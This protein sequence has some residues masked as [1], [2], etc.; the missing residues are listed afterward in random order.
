MPKK[1][2]NTGTT[3]NDGTGDSLKV[4]AG[5]VNDNFNEIYTAFGDGTTLTPGAV[6]G[7]AQGIKG[8]V[9]AQGP[10]GIQG[11]IGIQGNLGI[12]GVQGLSNQGI[13]GLDGQFAGQ[14]VQGGRGDIGNSGNQGVQGTQ[15][16]QGTT[17]SA[18][19]IGGPGSQGTTGPQGIQGTSGL[20]GT[21]GAQGAVGQGIQGTQ[22]IQGNFGIQGNS[23]TFGPQG[24]TGSV[25]SPGGQ[26]IQGTQ[27]T[28]G[29]QGVPGAGSQGTIG[30]IGVQ[31]NSGIQ[32][33]Q[34]LLGEGSQGTI[35]I[36]GAGGPGGLTG[37][38]GVQGTSVQGLS[39]QGV[40][41]VEGQQGPIG[42]SNG[43]FTPAANFPS[44]I[45]TSASVGIGTTE[46]N[47]E[48][49]V[50]DN[51]EKLAVGIVTCREIF[52][53][54]VSGVSTITGDVG[55]AGTIAATHL[56]AGKWTLGADGVS[57][58]TFTGPGL[59]GA[60]NDPTITLVRGQ[61][62]QFVNNMGAH[63]FRIQ[64]TPNG[65]T[66]PEYNDGVTNNNVTNGT[67]TWNVQFDAPDILYYQCTAHPNMGGKINISGS[68]SRA[69]ITTNTGSLG[70]GA[71]VN[72]TFEGYKSYSL[73][74][75]EVSAPSWITIYS[76]TTTRTADEERAITEDPTAGS[77]VIAEIIT[78]TLPETILFTPAVVGFNN[79]GT[80]SRNVYLK[81]N[82]RTGVSTAGIAITF[83]ML[84]LED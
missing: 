41:G 1:I 73:L 31:G 17:G 59:T 55:V 5:K 22:G 10:Q 50:F 30:S 70:I 35:G 33:L 56:I 42:P 40:Q 39:N 2:I 72:M 27:S 25:G 46:I 26:G 84:K 8:N 37:P 4:G 21:L 68:R 24:T 32:G 29:T 66:G 62:Y 64:S 12:Q 45:S 58:Y 79:D 71:S 28:Q 82:N 63:P 77:G 13:Q 16:T 54:G 76:D 3:D 51:P 7:G 43:F 47:S 60:E 14:G 61:E 18:G 36:Q 44:G 53:D 69:G 15:A 65:S 23:G 19:P 38:Q 49:A 6:G 74:K 9:G 34:G 78:T 75:A 67:L 80:P 81:V 57:N 20:Q 11:T 48:N 52:V 83:T